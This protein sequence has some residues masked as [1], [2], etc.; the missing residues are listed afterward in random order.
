MR[1]PFFCLE[2]GII[3]GWIEAHALGMRQLDTDSEEQLAQDELS[4][5][6]QKSEWPSRTP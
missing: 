1:W 5:T 6:V 3:S 4:M 2:I